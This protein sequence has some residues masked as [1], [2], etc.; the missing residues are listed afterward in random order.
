MDDIKRLLE[1]RKIQKKRKP[2]FLRQDYQRRKRLKTKLNWKRP[3]GLHSKMRLHKAG[4]RK[5]VGTGFKS[6]ALVK[7]FHSSGVMPVIIHNKEELLSL[8][9]KIQGAV[10]SSKVGGRKR[11][12]V[13]TA[14]IE[15][16]IE[17]LN[18][19]DAKGTCEAIQHRVEER[20]KARAEKEAQ[21]KK[22]APKKK[23]EEKVSE[24][25]DKLSDEEKKKLEKAEKDKILTKRQV[26]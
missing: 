21:K 9:P 19:K 15:K 11:V 23:L 14:A 24:A 12:E 20:K 18:I 4:H 7:G 3:K 22:A 1:A 25:E 2:V 17:V 10:L 6:P 26:D 13:L 8:N 16:G 5:V